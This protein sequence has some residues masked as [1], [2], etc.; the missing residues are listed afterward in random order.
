MTRPFEGR[1]ALITGAA[2]GQ[3]RSHA[4]ALAARGA[5]IIAVDACAPDPAAI[6]PIGTKE[7]LDETCD[8]IGELGA[9]AVPFVA[10]VAHDGA[11]AAVVARAL[12]EFGRIDIAVANAAMFAVGTTLELDRA[13]FQRVIDVDLIGAWETIRAVLPPMIEANEGSIITIGSTAATKG[14]PNMGPYVAAKHGLVGLTKTVANEVGPHSV[15]VN[16][17]CPTSTNTTMLRNEP[18]RR[19]FTGGI[20][21]DDLFVQAARATHVL[22]VSWIEPGDITNAVLFFAG[23]ESRSCT[24]SILNVDAGYTIK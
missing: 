21:D 9:H 10:D 22:P 4:L 5:N 8:R 16:M 7:Q 6:H 24:G 17:V 2:M 1:V 20:D 12:D 3:G 23:D 18:T 11:M 19:I 13:T 15:R 14:I